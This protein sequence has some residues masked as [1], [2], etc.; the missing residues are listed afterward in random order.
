MIWCISSLSIA[1]C[2]PRNSSSSTG[3]VLEQ[4]CANSALHSAR[5]ASQIRCAALIYFH[6]HQDSRPQSNSD[7]DHVITRRSRLPS[8]LRISRGGH[9]ATSSRTPAVGARLCTVRS[10][11]SQ[12]RRTHC[13]RNCRLQQGSRI[14]CWCRSGLEAMLIVGPEAGSVFR[15][16]GSAGAFQICIIFR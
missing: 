5:D 11:L 3:S 6:K 12:N 2:D 8:D 1:S 10:E 16:S 14:L 9:V 4:G 15:S 7:S 13:C